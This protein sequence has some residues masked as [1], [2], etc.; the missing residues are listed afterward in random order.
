MES[1]PQLLSLPD[2]LLQE[3]LLRIACP[4]DL[5]RASAACIAFCRF[6]A[7][8][9]FLRRYRSRHLPLL[10]GFV[11]QGVDKGFHAVEA[12]H[13]NAPAAR[14]LANV[15]FDFLPPPLKNWYIGNV[16]DGRV[17]FEC[18]RHD[19]DDY[20]NIIGIDAHLAVWDP[21]SCSRQN[22]LLPPVPH[23]QD[24]QYFEAAFD[25]CAHKDDESLFRVISVMYYRTKLV[26][27][28]FDSDS[29]SWTIGT[30]ASWDA[31][32]LSN[33]GP[34]QFFSLPYYA[35]GCFYWKIDDENKLLKLDI[36]RMEFSRVNLPPDHEEHNVVVVEAGEDRLGLLSYNPND[37]KFLNYYNSMQNEDQRTKEW[38]MKKAI[39]LLVNDE[40]RFFIAHQG[41]IFIQADSNILNTKR[42]TIYSLDIKTLE[43]EMFR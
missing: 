12:P 24:L 2:E 35:Y 6:I 34:W 32:S 21:S 16:C 43:L 15:T 29:N 7:D 38:Q 19:D 20:D 1:L 39:P 3:I 4:A 8:P 14:A 30:S 33:E 11:G 40:P 25:P 42:T 27:L 17:V 28:V 13:P 5:A 36:R 18:F 9:D 31:L 23:G 26:V 37:G 22:L 41:C 10:L